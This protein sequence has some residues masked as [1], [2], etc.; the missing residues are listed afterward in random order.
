MKRKGCQ[1]L[2]CISIIIA[3]AYVIPTTYSLYSK[4]QP[5]NYNDII[6]GMYLVDTP[7]TGRHLQS[8]TPENPGIFFENT[9]LP[10]S[11]QTNQF[12][13]SQD[14]AS[15]S[16]SGALS[17]NR[18]G[19]L[20]TPSDPYW[21]NKSAAISENHPFT[22]W[23][24]TENGYYEWELIISGMPVMNIATSHSAEPE[25][26]A[27][28][29]DPDKYVYD[30]ETLYYG[31]VRLFNPG[32]GCNN[33]E[34]TECNLEYHEKGATSSCF[35][36]KSYSLSLQSWNGENLSVSLLG[37]RSDN[38]WKL[39]AMVSDPN[40]IR[41][42]TA[43]E[44]WAEFDAAETSVIETGP[45]AEYVEVIL[46]NDYK[47]IYCLVEPVDA[48]KLELDSHDILYKVLAWE[49]PADADIQ[50]SINHGWRIIYPVRIRHPKI[51]TD[52]T[53]AWYPIRDY[54]NTF[55]R[56]ET[57]EDLTTK[58]YPENVADMY[59]FLMAVSGSDNSFK[60]MY[61]AADVFDD[62]SYKMRQI[63]W[64]LDLTFGNIYEYN[65]PIASEFD[66]DSHVVYEEFAASK[67]L[68][69][70]P[71]TLMPLL[72]SKWTQYRETFLNTDVI[73]EK[74]TSNRDYLMNTGAFLRE[75]TRW[76]D[77]PMSSD[78]NYLLEY[79]TERMNWLDEYIMTMI[80]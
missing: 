49:P 56:H 36:K 70:A 32:I 61:Y 23:L 10:Y 22:V 47:G 15:P 69:S 28:E 77:Y 27:Y 48:K 3:L 74:L 62:G 60:N 5:A 41:E 8:D 68:D 34:I 18:K 45:K 72:R 75:Q 67:L 44:I 63:P 57:Y 26:I 4:Q 11:I 30:S 78:I 35:S 29:E 51:I 2:I 66:S 43:S 1:I 65:S 20:C 53:T 79:Q 13:L 54:L 76:P 71:D 25:S 52:Y 39:N 24:V 12:Y 59:L 33:Y 9:L 46:D 16:W 58:L 64:D 17:T 55:Y 7:P 14:Y 31:N 38:N 80:E 6:M 73:L 21:Q 37:M 50:D 19:Y 42:K 40:R